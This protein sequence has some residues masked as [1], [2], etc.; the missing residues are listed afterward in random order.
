MENEFKEIKEEST[1]RAFQELK[2]KYTQENKIELL[3]KLI[4]LEKKWKN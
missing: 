2:E 3:I 1:K 4:E